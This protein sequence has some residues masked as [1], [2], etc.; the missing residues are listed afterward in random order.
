MNNLEK[1][2]NF[3]LKNSFFYNVAFLSI[4]CL[5]N[6]FWA[7]MT[8]I[9]FPI[10]ALLVIFDNLE[11]GISYIIFFIPFCFL[12]ASI[13][14]ILIL[15][16]SFI[17]IV[18]FFIINFI[19]HKTKLNPFV[20]IC[21][22]L[23]YIYSALPIGGF[24][25]GKLV[26][27]T[28]ITALFI[29]VYFV[30]LKPKIFRGNFNVKVLCYSII[31]SSIFSLTYFFSPYLQDYLYICYVNEN[32]KRFM[33]LFTNP[34][35]LAMFCEVMLA[36]LAYFIVSKQ[37]RIHE[38]ILFFFI[39]IIGLLTFSKT[40]LII[41]LL[42]SL[43]LIIY[44]LIKNY[45][46]TLLISL[47]IIAIVIILCIIF[48]QI[49]NLIKDRFVGS[50]NDCKNFTDFMN[51]VTTGRYDLW[52]EYLTY[53]GRHPL[54]LIFGRGAGAPKLQE[55]SSHNAYI[56]LIYEFGI[57]GTLLF[58]LTLGVIIKEIIR[59]NNNKINWAVLFPIITVCLIL[60]VENII[61]EI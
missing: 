1:L 27:M 14:E 6:C 32:L 46:K 55:L 31:I 15:A 8:F 42:I 48:P 54:V 35:V 44:S 9:V 18:K 60:C 56:T 41:L 29:A 24:T 12:N 61:F 26:R 13:A 19:I 45:K 40:F 52:I 57:V 36:F 21:I 20:I 7:N 10:L 47:P 5:A 16:C 38:L 51:M 49:I 11:N 23:F 25:I 22:A 50:I 17:Y 43:A 30:S 59:S 58:A 2:K 34:N 39:A 33:A 53:I 4:L 37:K 28:V 3:Y